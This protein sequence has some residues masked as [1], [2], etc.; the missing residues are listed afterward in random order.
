[1]FCRPAIIRLALYDPEPMSSPREPHDP[2][3]PRSGDRESDP[4]LRAVTDMILAM[5]VED[6]LVQLEAEANFFASVRPLAD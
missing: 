3:T 6:R 2:P 5:P 1:M 4:K